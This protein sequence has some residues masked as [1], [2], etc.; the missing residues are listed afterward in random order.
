MDIL[1]QRDALTRSNDVSGTNTRTKNKVNAWI[2]A[3]N[4]SWF[5]NVA[6][7]CAIKPPRMGEPQ[8]N[9]RLTMFRMLVLSARS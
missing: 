9:T 8:V 4:R 3:R 2:M 1:G 7:D 6:L 5:R